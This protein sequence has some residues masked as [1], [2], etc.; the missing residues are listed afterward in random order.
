MQCN[1]IQMHC[2]AF[3]L[4]D[5]FDWF[6]CFFQSIVMC[7]FNV[8]LYATISIHLRVQSYS[9]NLFARW[10]YWIVTVMAQDRSLEVLHFIYR[11]TWRAGSLLHIALY[12][13]CNNHLILQIQFEIRQDEKKKLRTMDAGR[14]KREREKATILNSLFEDL[15]H[16]SFFSADFFG[17]MKIMS[18]VFIFWASEFCNKFT[19]INVIRVS[20]DVLSYAV[21]F[22]YWNIL[23]VLFHLVFDLTN[24]KI[25]S[26]HWFYAACEP[27]GMW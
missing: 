19:L 11:Q 9:Q 23:F 14:Q 18:I 22:L 3:I 12:Q 20:L 24:D 16:S 8:F 2:I 5:F 21:F 4:I 15:A 26:N 13:I 10:S 25:L 1:A 7:M 6:F 17:R 27:I